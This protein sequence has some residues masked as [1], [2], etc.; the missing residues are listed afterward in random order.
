MTSRESLKRGCSTGSAPTPKRCKAEQNLTLSDSDGSAE[1][2]TIDLP[3]NESSIEDASNYTLSSPASSSAAGDD[4]PVAPTDGKSTPVAPSFDDSSV[5]E[6][7]TST[8]GTIVVSG[9]S[10]VRVYNHNQ[11][12]SSHNK[13]IPVWSYNLQA[14]CDSQ[15]YYKAHESGTYTKQRFVL[16]VR[17]G[18]YGEPRDMFER[19][20]IITCSGGNHFE[21]KH[22]I[23]GK[24]LP[25]GP[26]GTA[27]K[28]Q[29]RKQTMPAQAQYW[30][31]TMK[32]KKSVLVVMDKEHTSWKSGEIDLSIIPCD[33]KDREKI[34]GIVLGRYYITALW[35]EMVKPHIKLQRIGSENPVWSKD[36][37]DDK[38]V[39]SEVPTCSEQACATCLM[40]SP[41][42]FKNMEWICLHHKCDRFFIHNGVK[43]M[44]NEGLEYS[45]EFINWAK[46]L[47]AD[48]DVPTWYTPLPSADNAM[49]G[50]EKGQFNGMVCPKC[51][52][53]SRRKHWKGW[54]CEN[55]KC[56]FELRALFRPV[57]LDHISCENETHSLKIQQ[58]GVTFNI[59]ERFVDKTVITDNDFTVTAY[60][61][62]DKNGKLAGSLIHS[63]PSEAIRSELQNAHDLE[64][65]RNAALHAG[66]YRETLCR[67]F[68]V[69]FGVAYKF[70]V[71]VPTRA[72]KNAP[73]VVLKSLAMLT[74]YG[75]QAVETTQRLI[76]DKGSYVHVP[77]SDIMKP[78]KAYNEELVLGYFEDNRIRWHDDGEEQLDGTVTTASCGSPSEMSLR[79]RGEKSKKVNKADN[80]PKVVLKVQLKHGDAVTMCGTQLQALS[81]HE[82]TPTGVRRFALTGR[83]I[84]IS[85]YKDQKVRDKMLEASHIPAH[86]GAY[87]FQGTHLEPHIDQ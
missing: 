74:F 80:S 48:L 15:E 54:V 30:E 33:N 40:K 10:K 70:R 37:T 84:N 42:I 61:I 20:C 3:T 36:K 63:R 75:K 19:D 39:Y 16:G 32:T 67:H 26:K 81:E 51:S 6:A 76:N 45:E 14:I 18:G 2:I 50:T 53:C 7:S 28:I 85:H 34:F 43:L 31:D 71:D 68:S 25:A 8:P 65:Q 46:P 1:S 79:L 87:E 73:H 82:V 60:L 72:F 11:L 62:K 58:D 23:T 66:G 57:T 69:N 35:Q 9:S 17:T 12:L 78:W 21:A 59:D 49:Y 4:K 55:N 29:I 86:A 44:G 47:P 24:S 13:G 83:T 27:K 41:K 56:S 22:P 38:R 77:S 64:L 5:D 52:C